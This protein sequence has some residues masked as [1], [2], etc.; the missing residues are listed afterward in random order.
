M[1]NNPIN[2]T[3]PIP[4]ETSRVW[5]TYHGG[6]MISRLHGEDVEDDNFPEEWLM[7]VVAARNAGR[8]HIVEGMSRVTGTGLTLKELCEAAISL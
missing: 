4:L 7:S 2:L 1:I 3:R 6:Q 8:E 5:R